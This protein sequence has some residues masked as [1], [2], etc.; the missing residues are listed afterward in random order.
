MDKILELQKQRHEKVQ[1]MEALVNDADAEKRDL[2]ATEID[3]YNTL[4]G[5]VEGLLTR[6][7]R[8]KEVEAL[9]QQTLTKVN[10]ST[11]TQQAGRGVIGQTMP[12]DITAGTQQPIERKPGEAFGR[13]VRCLTAKRGIIEL[14]ARY[15]EDSLNDPEIAHALAA[16]T[17]DS[18]GYIVPENYAAEVIELLRPASVVRSLG[19]LAW[20][21]QNGNAR[22]PKLT[23]GATSSYIGENRAI[24]VSQQTFGQILLTARKLAT[25]VP[26]SN[27]LI[28]FSSPNADGIVRDDMVR[29]MAQR[30]DLAFLRDPGSAATPK[31]LRYFVDPK[32]IVVSSGST[33][34]QVTNDLGLMV[35][36]LEEA[37]VMIS[38]GAWIMTPR[39]RQYLMDLRDGNGNYAFRPEMI[40]GTLQGYTYGVSNQI[41]RN[42]N[43]NETEL[44]FANMSDFIVGDAMTITIDASGDASYTEG[45]VTTSAFQNDQTVVRAIS[46]HDTGMRHDLSVAVMTGITWN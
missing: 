5:E 19:P 17:A 43:G 6:I 14:A 23:G 31:G 18:G 4:K 35:L 15:A 11:G 39:S 46:E 1:A 25:L 44:Y 16:G 32:N 34:D 40:D 22:V 8:L 9:M 30:E 12:V 36:A 45:G 26:I 7:T 33:L 42:I 3:A 37:N 29:S 24:P 21:L 28:R 13:L 20:P 10:E 27:D 41:P 38:R 2:N